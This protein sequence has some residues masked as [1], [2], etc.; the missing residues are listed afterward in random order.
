MTNLDRFLNTALYEFGSL[1]GSQHASVSSFPFYNVVKVDEENYK[2]ELALAGYAREDIKISLEYVGPTRVLVVSGEHK[3]ENADEAKNYIH[4]GIS[5]KNFRRT[6]NLNENL[7]VGEAEYVNGVLSIALKKFIP[8][9]R[10]PLLI[11]IK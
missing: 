11:E 10:K 6:F 7:Q 9:E 4:R 3:E 2:I 5:K 1:L 8:E